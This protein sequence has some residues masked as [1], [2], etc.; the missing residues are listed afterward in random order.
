MREGRFAM[1]DSEQGMRIHANWDPAEMQSYNQE[2]QAHGARR[3]IE[4]SCDR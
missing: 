3:G 4:K 2:Q 1:A